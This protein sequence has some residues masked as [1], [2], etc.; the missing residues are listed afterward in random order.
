MIDGSR[1]SIIANAWRPS[2][3]LPE[4]LSPKP[5]QPCRRHEFWVVLK[6]KSSIAY[7]IRISE[8]RHCCSHAKTTALEKCC[9][10][11]AAVLAWGQQRFVLYEWYYI[12]DIS[13]SN[14]QCQSDIDG[15]V[16]PGN[17]QRRWTRVWCCVSHAA[18]VIVWSMIQSGKMSPVVRNLHCHMMWPTFERIESGPLPTVE[19]VDFALYCSTKFCTIAWQHVPA[20]LQQP[21]I[22]VWYWSSNWWFS[23]ES[24]EQPRIFAVVLHAVDS[25]GSNPAGLNPPAGP[26]PPACGFLWSTCRPFRRLDPPAWCLLSERRCQRPKFSHSP[27]GG[28]YD[29]LNFN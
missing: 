16:V 12:I 14:W 23:I 7:T 17:Y 28:I 19:D 13:Q 2:P 1:A 6:M 18:Y 5:D 24:V 10:K 25:F 29:R 20:G 11:F 15:D 4:Q 26:N 8:V 22:S 21:T 3:H 9:Q 27:Q